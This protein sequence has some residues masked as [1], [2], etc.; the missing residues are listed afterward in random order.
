MSHS[1]ARQP[2]LAPVRAESPDYAAILDGY[3]AGL[4]AEGRYRSFQLHD[5]RNGRFPVSVIQ[6]AQG[7]REVVV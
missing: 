3:L 5:R 4:R 6:T 2:A 7:P 1:L